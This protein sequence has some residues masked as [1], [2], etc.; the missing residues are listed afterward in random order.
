MES[1]SS[2]KYRSKTAVIT[3][4]SGGIG[5]STAIE[6]A[7]KGMNLVLCSNKT[8]EE[9]EIWGRELAFRFGVEVKLVQ[10][11]FSSGDQVKKIAREITQA[12]DV[13]Y[14]VNCAG[15]PFGATV[16]MTSVDDLQRVLNINFINQVLFTQY[17]VK[18]MYSQRFGAVVN[19]AS[20]VGVGSDIGTL[21]YGASK[22]ALMHFTKVLASESGKYGV[23]VNSVSPGVI[24]TNMLE[25]M[26]PRVL[27]KKLL[28]SAQGRIGLPHEVAQT[29]E[30]LLSES[31]SYITGQSINVNGGQIC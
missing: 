22:A 13:Q 28:N 25:A 17:F 19:I 14:L 5:R 30:F 4:A 3:G 23:R 15:V 26:D 12:H 29:V 24:E 1:S 6:L 9:W 20:M 21:A 2:E 8:N 18:K 11:D 10:F 31:S 16:L 27:E 7:S